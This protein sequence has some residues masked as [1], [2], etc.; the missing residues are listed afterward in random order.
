MGVQTY[1][2][3]VNTTNNLYIVGTFGN[4]ILSL[5]TNILYNNGIAGT[6]DMFIAKLDAFAGIEEIANEENNIN[7]Y[8]NPSDG[9]FTIRQPAD[10]T[11]QP[12]IYIY[13]SLGK[14]VYKKEKA[15]QGYEV[16]NLSAYS[17][18][19]YF[20]KVVDGEKSYSKK[21]ILE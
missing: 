4:N 9:A 2:I 13:N 10:G 3:A 6:D 16:I 14:L 12:S 21:V 11:L 5:G 19:I 8:P 17:K 20:I 7:V 1:S 18:G 15:A